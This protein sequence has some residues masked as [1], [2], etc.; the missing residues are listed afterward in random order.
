MYSATG[1]YVAFLKG[2]GEESAAKRLLEEK[3]GE[4]SELRW[5]SG[6]QPPDF[7]LNNVLNQ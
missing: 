4:Q 5:G 7:F 6:A 3:Y 1:A 2:L